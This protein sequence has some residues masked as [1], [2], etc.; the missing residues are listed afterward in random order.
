MNILNEL[1]Q[2]RYVHF[3]VCIQ[4]GSAFRRE[5]FGGRAIATGIYI[6]PKCGHEGP[7]NVEIRKVEDISPKE[8]APLGR[9]SS[10]QR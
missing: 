4:C 3:H 1:R 7:L 10:R 2:P 6:C 5:A 8:D 9:D